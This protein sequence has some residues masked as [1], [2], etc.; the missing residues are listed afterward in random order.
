MRGLALKATSGFWVRHRLPPRL[1]S[2]PFPGRRGSPRQNTNLFIQPFNLSISALRRFVASRPSSLAALS[3]RISMVCSRLVLARFRPSMIRCFSS[4]FSTC[5]C[6]TCRNIEDP[7]IDYGAASSWMPVQTRTFRATARMPAT[8][9][10]MVQ[11][12]RLSTELV[13]HQNCPTADGVLVLRG[14]SGL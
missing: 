6:Q 3:K 14:L 4:R 8:G 11:S 12:L 1:I 5:P 13:R 9:I 10:P 2:L 7:I